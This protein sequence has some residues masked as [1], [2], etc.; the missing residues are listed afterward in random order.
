VPPAR[1][2][3]LRR[4]GGAAENGE[5]GSDAS[6]SYSAVLETHFVFLAVSWR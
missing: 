6:V 1:D 5:R 3:F 2:S 4:V